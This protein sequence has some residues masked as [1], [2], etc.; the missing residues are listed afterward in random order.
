L[1]HVDGQILDEVYVWGS[2]LSSRMHL[3][4]V[5]CS[6]CHDPH[7]TSLRRPGNSTCTFCHQTEP[8]AEFAGA[9]P[10]DYDSPEHHFHPRG[11]AGAECVACHMPSK[12]YMGVDDRR[13][14][15]FRIPRPDLSATLGVPEPCTGCHEDRDA[16]WAATSIAA[17]FG[18]ARPEHFASTFAAADVVTAGADAALAELVQ[19]A[20]TPIMVRASALARLGAYD[21][22]YT[23]D[24]IRLARRAEPLMRYAAP[25]AAASLSPERAWRLLTPLLTDEVRAVRH[26]TISALLPTLS[27]DP[28]YRTRLEPHLD[29]WMKDQRLNLDYPETL[30]N[31]AGA[32]VLLGNLPAAE[33]ALQESLALQPSWVPGLVS[34]AD[35]YRATGR[36][37]EAGPL[38]EKALA[39]TP[40]QGEVIYAYALWLSRQ[41]R[42]DEAL[43]H[44]ER[45]ARSAPDQRQYGYAWAVALN[46]SG[47]SERAVSELKSLLERWPDDPDLLFA[48]VTMLRDQGR[49][50][51]AL[52]FLDRLIRQ[53]PGDQQLIRFRE[54]L[55]QAA[56]AS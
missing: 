19:D 36:D 49:F 2:F 47:E 39:L 56:S 24:A 9:G 13:D 40:D 52:V 16:R 46:G 55:A 31:L 28:A 11:S 43:T 17:H 45:A 25:L 23:M 8:P 35:L 1:Y 20:G 15:S 12:T 6:N 18:D 4:G 54:V 10:V 27:V 7:S 34:L 30:T 29:A 14:H 41:G 5:T 38:F 26:Q 51:E 3:A 44:L 22:G 32:H 33:A 53:R 50:S 42:A 21:R 48:A 37:P